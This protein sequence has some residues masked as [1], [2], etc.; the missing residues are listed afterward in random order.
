MTKSSTPRQLLFVAWLLSISFL[1]LLLAFI[2][3][4]AIVRHIN[5]GGN[6]LPQSITTLVETLA[7]VPSLIKSASLT[8]WEESSGRPFALIIPRDNLSQSGWVHKFPAPDDDGYLLI[9]G[10]SPSYG[11]SIVQLIRIAD[12]RVIAKWVPDWIGINRQITGHR[13]SAKGNPYNSL[14]IH[15]LLLNDGSIIFNTGTSLIRLPLCSRSPSWLLNYNFHHSIEFSPSGSSIW[16]PSSTEIFAI[17]N[18]ILKHKLRDDSLS[19]ISLDGRIIQNLS[20]SKILAENNMMA[21]LL[22]N[23][24]KTFNSDPI[25]IN[26]ITPAPSDTTYWKKNDL[27]ISA[28]HTSTIYLF[29]PSTGKIIW[30]QQGPWLN[31][32]SVHFVNNHA[33]AVFGNDIH[34]KFPESPFVYKDGHNQIYQ[35]DF[36]LKRTQ[37]LHQEALNNLK[38][39]TVTEG[40]V[41]VFEDTSF[42]V[43]ETEN[44]RLFKI[45]SKG[46]L[47]WS[48]IN[49]YDAKNLG[50]LAWSRYL[51]NKELHSNVNFENLKCH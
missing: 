21:H 17:E 33:I 20:F 28:R 14:P 31:Q 7:E 3:G 6:K 10:A 51:T 50:A 9:S 23:S 1:A 41:R 35:Y 16:V 27:L 24:G 19:E 39:Q 47:I 40:R 8:L 38:P 25:H 42:F 44:S 13:F 37:K 4:A 11:Q 29:R 30:H 26:Q 45:D 43:E 49:T 48:Y 22:G 15:P 34:A 36:K 46:K 18:V 32:H 12:G 5:K 2:T